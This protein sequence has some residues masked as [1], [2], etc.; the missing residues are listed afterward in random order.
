MGTCPSSF[1]HPYPIHHLKGR[2]SNQ[3]RHILQRILFYACAAWAAITLDFFIPR[4]APGDPV[5]ALVGKMSTKG[6]VTPAMQHAVWTEFG[7]NA[8]EPLV[9][10]YFKYL[11]NL[12]HGK[13]G[14]S[15]Q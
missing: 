14:K 10:Q 9:V 3:V 15:I 8:H 4:L 13:L 1:A 7:L 6:Y 2:R 12:I 5:A 11:G